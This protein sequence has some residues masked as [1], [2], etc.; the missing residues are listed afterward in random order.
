MC[1]YEQELE[2]LPHLPDMVFPRNS[3]TISRVDNEQAWLRFDALQALKRVDRERAD[4]SVQVAPS[5][6]W[7]QSRA[8]A[9]S[10]VVK[11][12]DWTF[13]TDFQGQ[14]GPAVTVRYV[15]AYFN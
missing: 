14:L 3:L 6:H 7:Q 8:D 9:N 13:T 10:Q 1:Q 4:G 15:A 11:P 5:K 2:G 12:F